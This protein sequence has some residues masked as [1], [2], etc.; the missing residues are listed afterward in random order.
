MYS[1]QSSF[2]FAQILKFPAHRGSRDIPVEFLANV[3]DLY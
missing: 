1:I 2:Q 3:R